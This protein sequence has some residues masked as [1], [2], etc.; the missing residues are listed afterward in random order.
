LREVACAVRQNDAWTVRHT[1]A[2]CVGLFLCVWGGGFTGTLAAVFV[3]QMT[4]VQFLEVGLPMLK[5][6]WKLAKGE[7]DLRQKMSAAGLESDGV[8]EKM[9]PEEEEAALQ[10]FEGVFSE[11]QEMVVQFG[12]VTLFAAAFPLTAALA[13]INNMVEIRTDAFKLLQ[14]RSVVAQPL[15]ISVMQRLFICQK[16]PTNVKRDLLMSCNVYSFLPCNVYLFP[17]ILAHHTR[18]RKSKHTR[19][20]LRVHTRVHTR[21]HARIHT[22]VRAA[23]GQRRRI[24]IYPCQ[25]AHTYAHT[26]AKSYAYIYHVWHILAHTPRIR[27]PFLCTHAQTNAHTHARARAHT[28]THTQTGNAAASAKASGRHRHLD[29]DPG[30]NCHVLHPHQLCTRWLHFAWY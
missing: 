26:C 1:D 6:K 22:Q 4:V 8:I 16:R 23:V 13:L 28:H 5:H 3:V 25:Y 29:G 7:A 18:I 30:H 10:Q 12:Y 21:T 20:H 15:L 9:K 24:S 17:D 11:Y 14:V 2:L 27:T 19:V